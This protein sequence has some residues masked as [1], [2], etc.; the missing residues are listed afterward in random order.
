MSQKILLS[1]RFAVNSLKKAAS[2]WHMIVILHR[3]REKESLVAL[4][5]IHRRYPGMFNLLRGRVCWGG[6]SRDGHL[7]AL[8]WDK[9]ILY[10]PNETASLQRFLRRIHA[11]IKKYA[12]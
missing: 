8:L 10:S 7:Q 1:S 11:K 4:R 9:E 5:H 3:K 2:L 6:S 12:Y